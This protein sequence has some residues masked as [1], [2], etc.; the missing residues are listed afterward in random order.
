MTVKFEIVSDDLRYSGTQRL[1]ID[2]D[3]VAKALKE[4]KTIFI[5]GPKSRN[6][7]RFSLK[8]RGVIVNIRKYKD[9]FIFWQREELDNNSE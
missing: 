6:S 8:R 9:G 2:W 3:D 1:Y 5:S 7:I 4:G